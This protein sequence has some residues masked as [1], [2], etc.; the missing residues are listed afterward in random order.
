M[1]SLSI[2]SGLQHKI[3]YVQ[4]KP[5]GNPFQP[6]PR[7]CSRALM[8]CSRPPLPLAEGGGRRNPP[9]T[10]RCGSLLLFAFSAGMC[11]Y[12]RT[13]TRTC[14]SHVQCTCHHYVYSINPPTHPL[15][16]LRTVATVGAD[17]HHTTPPC[18]MTTPPRRVAGDVGHRART[19]WAAYSHHSL[20][21]VWPVEIPLATENA[22]EVT[23][24]MPVTSRCGSLL[25]S[26]FTDTRSLDDVIA[27]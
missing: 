14:S 15:S 20:R 19:P 5:P 3:T 23:D 13:H 22:L 27:F 9:V 25:P 8:D 21:D 16:F 24:G 1:L 4:T 17:G 26:A 2:L 6:A 12:T 10:P 11:A 18:C 7:S